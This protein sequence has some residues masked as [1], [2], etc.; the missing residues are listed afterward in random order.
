MKTTGATRSARDDEVEPRFVYLIGRIDRG[1]RK[2]L[3]ATLHD[4][5]LS[6]SEYTTLSVLKLRPGLSNAQLAR[7]SLIAPQSM[8]DVIAR[9][10]RRGLVT[11]DTDPSHGRILQTRLTRKGGALLKRA[12]ASV[13]DFEDELLAGLSSA[14]RKT[15]RISLASVMK[16][17]RDDH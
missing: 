7:R 1:L 15:L 14:E 2:R 11:R 16:R 9:L 13:T 8:I 4:F 10:E 5:E 6:V 17:L 12:Q 3:E